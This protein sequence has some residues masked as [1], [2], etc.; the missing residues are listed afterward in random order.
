MTFSPQPFPVLSRDAAVAALDALVAS[1]YSASLGATVV[2][3]NT[4]WRV[5]SLRLGD[6]RDHDLTRLADALGLDLLASGTSSR[7][8]LTPRGTTD[9]TATA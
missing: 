8:A 1:G 4:Y 3:A 2:G 7:F 6:A 5:E 9:P